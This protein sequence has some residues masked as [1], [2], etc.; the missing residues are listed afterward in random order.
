MF[1]VSRKR[2]SSARAQVMRRLTLPAVAL[3]VA[4]AFFPAGAFADVHAARRQKPQPAISAAD[5]AQ[6]IH[7]LVNTERANH[8]LPALTWNA[9]LARIAATHSRDMARR[10]YFSHDSPEGHDFSHRYRLAGYACQIHIGQTIHAGAENIALARLYNTM[11]VE[12]GISYYDWNSAQQ[13]ARQTVDDWMQ[14]PGHRKNILTPHWR[15]QGIG[16]EIGP[17]N[18][19]L[20]T[21]NFC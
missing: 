2:T 17:G 18:K 21:Q 11:A 7:V 8:K 3:L 1:Q 13:I 12:N 15:H 14:S 5:L 16:V 20:V 19:V 10:D 9:A 6:R 4:A